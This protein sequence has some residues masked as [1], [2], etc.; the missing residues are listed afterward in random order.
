MIL[1][2]LNER[3]DI[4]E[5]AKLNSAYMNFKKLLTELN[6]RA[7]PDEINSFIN[8]QVDALNLISDS[9]KE[10]KKQL[11]KKRTAIVKRIENDLKIV[12]KNHYRNTWLILGMTIYGVPLGVV[13]GAIMGNMGLL[14]IGLPIGMAIGMA[15]GS[16]MDK[17]AVA[18][19]RQLDVEFK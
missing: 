4:A 13:F 14:G 18:E 2:E 6:I 16:K 3:N 12:P 9:G 10:F 19:G 8:T 5:N 1:K 15:I 11:C 17:K 7:L